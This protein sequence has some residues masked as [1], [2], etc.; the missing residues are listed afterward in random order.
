MS[1]ARNATSSRTASTGHTPYAVR[2]GA[3]G[4]TGIA[5]LHD[6]L[7]TQQY[8]RFASRKE[9]LLQKTGRG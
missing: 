9:S 6:V 2:G 3:P 7:N 8:A 1:R 4:A 5:G